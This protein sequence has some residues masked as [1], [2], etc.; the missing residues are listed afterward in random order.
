MSIE[1]ITGYEPKKLSR[2][3]RYTPE[4]VESMLSQLQIGEIYRFKF[5]VGHI[6][7]QTTAKLTGIEYKE[8]H[9][10]IL[11]LDARPAI[12][13]LQDIVEFSRV[14][15]PSSDAEVVHES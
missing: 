10:P 12:M 6:N 2:E 15:E 3:D 9:K 1:Q 7:Y 14:D 13:L 8:N 5:M 4:Q 11:R